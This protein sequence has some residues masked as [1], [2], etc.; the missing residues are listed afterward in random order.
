[1]SNPNINQFAQTPVQGQIDLSYPGNSTVT[2][3]VSNSQATALIAGQA[4]IGDNATPG[5]TFDGPPPVLAMTANSQPCLGFVVRNIKDQSFAANA[6]L[7]LALDGACL[8]VTSSAANS[9]AINRFGPV[10]FDFATNTVLAW[11]GVNPICGYAYDASINAG[12]VFRILVRSPQLGTASSGN[13]VRT[14][15][16]T[17][18]LAQIN[19][20][21]SLISG[22]A[23]KAITVLDYTARVNG[24]SFAGG[25]N[26]KLQSS[27]GTPVVVATM[28]EADLVTTA[29]LKPTSGSTVLGAGFS[30]PLGSGDGLNIASTG[31]HTTATGIT[32][33][34]TYTQA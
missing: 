15:N 4:V 22:I 9:G 18:T 11:G 31:T 1:M 23:G 33:T 14:I 3:R 6:R 13:G 12:D 32:L 28:V 34:L 19:A 29:V 2:G 17:K 26:I 27:N 7:E 24:A 16:I 25:T 30:V 21:G 5:A 10:E 8:Y 20:G